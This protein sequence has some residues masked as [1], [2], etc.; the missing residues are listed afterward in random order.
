MSCISITNLPRVSSVK[1]GYVHYWKISDSQNVLTTVYIW[2]EV[3]TCFHIKQFFIQLATAKHSNFMLV[4]NARSGSVCT[5][6]REI[7]NLPHPFFNQK[8]NK[9]LHLSIG[10]LDPV[11]LDHCVSLFPHGSVRMFRPTI[12]QFGKLILW[13]ERKTPINILVNVT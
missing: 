11:Y 1:L 6:L 2:V 7:L 4:L 13:G 9:S 5:Q 3:L 8:K 10:R 12:F